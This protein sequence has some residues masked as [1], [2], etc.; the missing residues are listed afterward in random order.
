MESHGLQV[1]VSDRVDPGLLNNNVEGRPC[2]MRSTRSGP[3]FGILWKS[4]QAAGW[5]LS[6]R[7]IRNA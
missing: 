1:G 6:L 4:G 3:S 2:G 5:G 7:R